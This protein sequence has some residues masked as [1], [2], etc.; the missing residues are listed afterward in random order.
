MVV[1]RCPDLSIVPKIGHDV[2]ASSC[3]AQ[4]GW[5]GLT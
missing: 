2:V 4:D 5:S 3:A 1:R